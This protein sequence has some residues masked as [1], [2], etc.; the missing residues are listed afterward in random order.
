MIWEARKI[1]SAYKVPRKK[2]KLLFGALILLAL[3]DLV[4][5]ILWLS[6]GAAEEANPLM[7]LL[8][9]NS[10]VS[11]AFG[12]LLLTFFGVAIL[13]GLRP[14]RP[15]LVLKATWSL[16]ILY[17]ILSVWHLVGFLRVVA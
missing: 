13:R 9:E 1:K 17:T 8:I 7:N 5:T 2:F 16:I 10:M 6:L 14:Q 4:A 15:K 11:F 3:F 12:K